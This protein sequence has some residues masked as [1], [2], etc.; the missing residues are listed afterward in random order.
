[1]EEVTISAQGQRVKTLKQLLKHANVDTKKWRVSSWRCNS[2]E[3]SVKGGEETIT[4]YQVKANLERKIEPDRNPAH[5]ARTIPRIE[6]V[7]PRVC[8]LRTTLFIPDLQLGFCWR[9]R[10]TYLEP[11]HDRVAM[12]AVMSL[13]KSMRPENIV[14]LG[15]MLDLAPWSTRFPRKPEYRQTTQPSIDELHWWLADLRGASPASKIVYMAGNHE[16]RV[17]R[18]IIELLPEASGIAPALETDPVLSLNRLL[19]LDKLDIEYIGPYGADWWLWPESNSPVRVTH[20]NKV[21]SGAGSTATAIAKSTRWSEV[22]GHIHKVEMVQKTFHGPSGPQTV[23]AMSPGCL[24][25]VP[26][27]TPGV[28]LAPDWQQAVGLAILDENTND[29]HIQLLP[30]TN[31]RLIWDGQIFEGHDPFERI[32][33]ETGWKQFIGEKHGQER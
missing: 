10:Y 22:Y 26:G 2:W 9:D 8:G 1:M 32:A 29:V 28:S 7:P 5:P 11:M 15:D 12:D 16:A 23:T 21:R 31:G 14:L 24:V 25:R 13:V 19:H 20:G 30:I 3:Q 4:L 33:F 18:A 17:D 27:P 6:S